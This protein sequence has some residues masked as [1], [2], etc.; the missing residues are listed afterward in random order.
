MGDLQEIKDMLITA[1]GALSDAMS[2][3]RQEDVDTAAA[4]IGSIRVIADR[5]QRRIWSDSRM[6]S[7]RLKVLKMRG[8]GS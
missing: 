7:H 2:M 1:H 4:A 5:S 3:G 8:N 6:R